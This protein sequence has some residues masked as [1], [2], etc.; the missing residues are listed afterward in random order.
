MADGAVPLRVTLAQRR[1]YVFA[2]CSLDTTAMH[3]VSTKLH[4]S[5]LCSRSALNAGMTALNPTYNLCTLNF[6][7]TSDSLVAQINLLINKHFN[8]LSLL[9]L[10]RVCLFIPDNFKLMST[11]LHVKILCDIMILTD[12]LYDNWLAS[13]ILQILVSSSL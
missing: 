2:G 8:A 5:F 4:P 12:D 10:P 13:Q 1:L 7:L 6:T 3:D 9:L 11:T